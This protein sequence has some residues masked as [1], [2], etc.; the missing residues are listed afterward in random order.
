MEVW[1]EARSLALV[2]PYCVL[3]IPKVKPSPS[4]PRAGYRMVFFII[5]DPAFG[6]FV[7]S[8]T[9]EIGSCTGL[10]VFCLVVSFAGVEYKKHLVSPL[11]FFFLLRFVV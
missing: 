11:F 4:G 1:G 10:T 8:R 9:A 3:G 2:A 5:L 7:G 6:R